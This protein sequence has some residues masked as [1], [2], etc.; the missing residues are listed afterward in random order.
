MEKNIVELFV[1]KVREELLK[2]LAMR[3]ERNADENSAMVRFNVV[4]V[5]QEL[6]ASRVKG[7]VRV[8]KDGYTWFTAQASHKGFYFP[9]DFSQRRQAKKAELEA[10]K[11][12][13]DV[14]I[15]EA[16][17]IAGIFVDPDGNEHFS[18]KWDEL[19]TA[20]GEGVAYTGAVRKWH[21]ETGSYD[22][23]VSAE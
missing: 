10:M 5:L 22:A 18:M 20:D 12:L 21:E 8:V 4:E 19:I 2:A 23:P 3:R 6:G 14:P 17:C 16:I 11:T 7:A 13:A 9:I 15:E 1:E